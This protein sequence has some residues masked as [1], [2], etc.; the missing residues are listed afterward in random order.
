MTT[1]TIQ[2]PYGVY[3]GVAKTETY[4]DGRLHDICLE[5]RN[6]IV[7]H[8]GDLIPFYGAETL[9][10]KNKASVTFHKNGMIKAVALEEQQE[11]MTPIGEL[12]A[13]L[14]TFYDTGEVHRVFPLDGCL[15]GF[16]TEED[17]RALSIP[18]S[19]KL[20]FTEFMALLS[21]I[22]FYK[23]GEIKSVTLFPGE[24]IEV[25]HRIY[26][27][28]KVRHGFA[29]YETGELASL[30]PAEP[31]RVKTPIGLLTA[32][33]P[34]AIGVNADSNSLRFDREGRPIYLRTAFNRI[35]ASRARDGKTAVFQP[36]VIQSDD[37]EDI[38]ML[39]PVELTFNY[40]KSTVG[41]SDG[42]KSTRAFHFEDKFYVTEN[43]KLISGCTFGNCKSCKN[44]RCDPPMSHTLSN[45]IDIAR[46]RSSS[47]DSKLI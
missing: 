33:D 44:A 25:T 14:I 39:D 19:F 15:S 27:P 35:I 32:F 36:T 17:E 42:K 45:F 10:R 7:T 5:D 28:I 46:Y 24:Q 26:G 23:S 31:V 20:E 41:I 18:L 3:S 13:E 6:V 43:S 11:V 8:A 1:Q 4:P 47:Q 38:A 2:T 16:W 12:P 9:R 37:D 21:G 29:Q 40:E 30:E 34:N 22:C